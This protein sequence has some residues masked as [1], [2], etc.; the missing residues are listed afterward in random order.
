MSI[1][2]QFETGEYQKLFSEGLKQV[3]GLKF[4]QRLWEKDGSLWSDDPA[5]HAIALNR[6]G[7]LDLPSRM[8]REVDQLDGFAMEK[9]FRKI[10]HVVHLGMGGS[11]LAPEVFF[12]TFGSTFDFPELIVLDSTDPD[13]IDDVLRMVNLGSTLFIVAS[14]SGSTIETSSLAKFFYD[15]LTRLNPGTAR[16]HFIAITDPGTVLQ[17]EAEKKYC[18]VF[19]NPADIGGRYSALSLFGLVPLALLGKDTSRLLARGEEREEA[20]GP[21]IPEGSSDAVRLGA[22]LGKLAESGINKLTLQASP[23]LST[24]GWWVEQLV[25]ES[26]GKEEKGILPVNDEEITAPDLYSSDRVFVYIKRHG[27]IDLDKEEKLKALKRK[28]FPLIVIETDDIYDLGG[29]IYDWEIAAAA[30]ASVVR[31]D[32]FDEP[33]VKESKDNTRRVLDGFKSTGRIEFETSPLLDGE[34]RVFGN[35]AASVDVAGTLRNLFERRRE[36]DYLAIMAYLP[37]NTATQNLASILQNSLRDRLQIPVTVG[38]GP[39]FL[40]STGQFHKGGTKNGLFLQ[41]VHDPK[42]DFEIPG[43]NYSFKILLRAQA[44]GDYLSLESKEK[45]VVSL[46]LVGDPVAQLDGIF[47][48][49]F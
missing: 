39:R 38:F 41:F 42:K 22:F 2:Y 3:A 33:N 15:Q 7:W 17:D 48:R 18:K 4:L 24:V 12:R 25:A 47:K 27:D 44:I 10:K 8:K 9:V 32:P 16:E 31:I 26:T 30:A 5:H 23:S 45:P 40:H 21:E 29:L 1:K 49:L 11:S 6:L 35:V 14:K 36:G 20:C 46:E 37:R 13:Q 43:E 28:K 19:L 34:V